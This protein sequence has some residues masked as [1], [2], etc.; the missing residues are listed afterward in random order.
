[1]QRGYCGGLLLSWVRRA[2][3]A[4]AADGRVPPLPGR[5]AS[6][7]LGTAALLRRRTSP[8]ARRRM[9]GVPGPLRCSRARAGSAPAEKGRAR[10]PFPPHA[11]TSIGTRARSRLPLPGPVHLPR[12]P[13]PRPSRVS[14]PCRGRGHLP[15]FAA[16]SPPA[17]PPE[18]AF[19][20][21]ET[22][23]TR[24]AAISSAIRSGIELA[25]IGGARD[26]RQGRSR[27]SRRDARRVGVESPLPA[28]ASVNVDRRRRTARLLLPWGIRRSRRLSCKSTFRRS[29]DR[30]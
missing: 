16:S 2:E 10:N 3:H 8:L 9:R 13:R 1:M 22:R 27:P 14:S 30:R 26:G 28:P 15:F 21:G 11:A 12:R 19:A 25:R 18:E 6:P 29:I 20:D 23:Y 7:A 5:M 4:P 17:D 24:A